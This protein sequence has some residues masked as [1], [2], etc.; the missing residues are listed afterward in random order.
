M[1][2]RPILI[3]DDDPELCKLVTDVLAAADFEVLSAPD[4]PSG[5][6]LARAAQPAVILLDMLMPGMDGITICEHLKQDPALRDIPVVSIT[7]SDDVKL[8][9]RAFRAGA[10]L[11][12]PK[13]LQ[14]ASLV[15]VVGLVSTPAPSGTASH[16]RRHDPRFPVWVPARCLVREDGDTSRE[17]DGHVGNVG[18]GG[19]LLWLRE[20]VVEGTT[21][22]LTLSV[23]E[24]TITAESDVIWHDAEPRGKGWFRH[25]LRLVRFPEESGLLRYKR[26]LSRLAAGQYLKT[27]L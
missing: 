17:V 22:H 18:L 25:G 9:E 24:G 1:A 20:I 6:E 15:H 5:I 21:L 27:T 19:L 7:A 10:E 13:P 3:I 11:F 23:P 4:G 16:G 14:A 12:L 8:T 2:S 26:F